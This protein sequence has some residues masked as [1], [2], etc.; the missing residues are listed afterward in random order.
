MLWPVSD[1]ASRAASLTPASIFSIGSGSPITPVDMTSAAPAGRPS[2]VSANAAMAAASVSPWAPVQ[3][4]ALPALITTAR[5]AVGL[6]CNA[7]LS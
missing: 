2:A 1:R 3:A 4:L 6:T 7:A 5:M